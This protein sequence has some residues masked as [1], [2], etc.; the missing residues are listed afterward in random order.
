MPPKAFATLIQKEAFRTTLAE[1]VQHNEKLHQK[2]TV[3][4]FDTA[5]KTNYVI[6]GLDGKSMSLRDFLTIEEFDLY[7]ALKNHWQD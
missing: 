5:A 4:F 1:I 6:K 2:Y 3:Q 7:L